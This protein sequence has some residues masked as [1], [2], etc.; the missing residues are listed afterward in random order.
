MISEFSLAVIKII[1]SIPAGKVATY[2]QIAELAGKPQASRGVSWILHSC[3]TRYNLPWHRVINSKGKISFDKMTVHYR[4]QK[5][6]LENESVLFNESDE[7]NL[8]KY[9]FKPS[10]NLQSAKIDQRPSHGKSISKKVSRF[11]RP[12]SF[13]K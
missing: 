11:L 1:Q 5:R 8:K 7:I 3:S 12:T 9:Q 13:V 6:R 4:R 10:K 2:K